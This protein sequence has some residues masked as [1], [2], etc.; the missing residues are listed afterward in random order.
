[1]EYVQFTEKEKAAH[2]DELAMHFYEQNFGTFSKSDTELLMFRFYLEKLIQTNQNDN[3]TIDYNKCS[4]YKISK[5]LGITQQRVRNLKVKNHLAKPIKF[6]WQKS[7]AGLLP[8]ARHDKRTGKISIPIP[9]PILRLE[10]EN[11]LNESGGFSEPC[12]KS[13]L[14]QI[15]PEYYIELQMEA[16]KQEDDRKEV[17]KQLK[18]EIKKAGKD[19]S[20]FDEKQIGKSLLEL[21]VDI[22]SILANICAIA[23]PGSVVSTFFSGLC[24]L[25]KP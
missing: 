9:D 2:F 20:L 17:C 10:I 1:M 22:S 11:Y 24:K 19:E 7:L 21:G 23:T 14:L 4:G 16:L 5:D 25:I 18:A 12:L 15:R 6:D 3:G 8:N 13:D